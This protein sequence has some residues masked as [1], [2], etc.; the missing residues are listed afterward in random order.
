MVRKRQ[1]RHYANEK[2]VEQN[3]SIAKRPQSLLPVCCLMF[4]HARVI[5]SSELYNSHAIC[6]FISLVVRPVFVESNTFMCHA[7][8]PALLTQIQWFP[9]R[10][11]LDIGIHD[12]QLLPN[13][14]VHRHVIQHFWM[15]CQV[16]AGIL[17]NDFMPG[18]AVNVN[19]HQGQLILP[20]KRLA[21]EYCCAMVYLRS[22]PLQPVAHWMEKS[23]QVAICFC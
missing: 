12:V 11:P 1:W 7:W 19:F 9:A 13:F 16:E 2:M 20:G 4:G 5:D 17:S 8:H 14:P 21:A 18:P 10:F 6:C 3:A 15:N 22:P 23:H